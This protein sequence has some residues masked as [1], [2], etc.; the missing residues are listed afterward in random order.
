MSNQDVPILQAMAL[1]LSGSVTV[2]S[3]DMPGQGESPGEFQ[4]GGY[5][6]QVEVLQKVLVH[7]EEHHAL[8]VN[9]LI[10]HSMG[11]VCVNMGDRNSLPSS[12]CM[13]AAWS[14]VWII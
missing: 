14:F 1:A 13:C 12:V 4:Y 8:K 6:Q 11:C 5:R 9:S 2:V 10:G 3:F 7:L